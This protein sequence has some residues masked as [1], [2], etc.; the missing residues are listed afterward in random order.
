MLQ[1]RGV[2]IYK[3]PV[4]SKGRMVREI[5]DTSELGVLT[6]ELQADL[7][8]LEALTGFDTSVWRIGNW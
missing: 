7:E 1:R 4:L 3:M 2:N 6:E 8:L 5:P